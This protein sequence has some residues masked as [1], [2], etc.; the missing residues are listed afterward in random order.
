[1]VNVFGLV[2]IPTPNINISGFISSTWWY[3]F[4]IA[5]IGFILI[6]IILL[7]FFFKTYKYKVE[8]YENIAGLGFRK[9][10]VRRARTLNLGV[11]GAEVLK[12]L[13]GTYLSAYGKKIATNT[14]MFVKGQDGYW[15]NSIHGDFDAKMGMLDI[16]PIDRDVRMYHVA[17]QRLA[18]QTYGKSSFLEKYGIHLMLFVFLIVML[19]GFYVIAGK[20]NE[21]LSVGATT[22]ATNQAVLENLQKILVAQENINNNPVESGLVPIT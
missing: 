12:V 9:V 6:T 21:G 3:I 22:S 8:F 1:M 13:L 5:T 11:G 14:Y 4:I 7:I 2:N 15:Y 20:I 19:I 10:A 16:E 17:L 18:Q